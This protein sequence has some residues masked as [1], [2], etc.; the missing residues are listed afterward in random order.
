MRLIQKFYLT[1][2]IVICLTAFLS[3]K[4][5]SGS[6]D[7]VVVKWE[8]YQ[9]VSTSVG[10]MNSA[11]I[12]GNFNLLGPASYY[13]SIGNVYEGKPPLTFNM[14]IFQGSGRFKFPVPDK[15]FV[16][17]TDS[18]I[19]VRSAITT[20]AQS[21]ETSVDMA[22]LNAGFS[23]FIDIPYWQGECLSLNKDNYLLA[24]FRSVN[25]GNSVPTPYF[26]LIKIRPPATSDNELM[27]YSTTN[28]Q[29]N[30]SAGE[31][32]VKRM[33]SFGSEFYVVMGAFTYRID[34]LGAMTKV[35]D[36]ELNIFQKGSELFAFSPNSN[37][38]KVEYLQS[39]DQGKS[40]LLLGAIPSELL[41][42]LKYTTIN[43]RLIGFTKGQIFLIELNGPSY[44]ITELEN[45]GLGLADITSI[46]MCDAKTVFVSSHCNSFSGDC[47]GYYKPL[48]YFFYKKL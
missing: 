46:N 20:V 7:P 30:V 45:S 19:I 35:A 37:T 15:Y 21:I 12:D 4:K 43:K 36:K 11:S 5:T 33:Q 34:T 42:S 28:I 44:S 38:G 6:T 18:R 25:N 3:C 39:I 1:V 24:P 2:I 29:N 8:K 27:I 41:V 31:I 23:Q 14:G 48:E 17:T 16:Y 40:W 32:T 26:E 47:G 13:N 10:F 22:A 9:G